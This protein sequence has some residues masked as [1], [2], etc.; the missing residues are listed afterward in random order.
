MRASGFEVLDRASCDKT[1]RLWLWFL[2][3]LLSR[4]PS[5]TTGAAS[6]PLVPRRRVLEHCWIARPHPAWRGL[7]KAAG[8]NGIP[9]YL[10][11]DFGWN[12]ELLS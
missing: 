1:S 5:R 12:N 11:V 4:W 9:W 6:P 7:A 2:A 10:H 3:G 8:Q